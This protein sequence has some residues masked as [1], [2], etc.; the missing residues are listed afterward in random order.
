MRASIAEILSRRAVVSSLVAGEVAADRYQA[1][2][3]AS[4]PS[5]SRQSA[6]A[7]RMIGAEGAS[8]AARAAARS[9]S[10]KRPA[11]R[12]AAATRRCPSA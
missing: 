1:A 9:A 5:R 11:P 12:Q 8:R 6:T 10:S 7:D 3:S 2:A 4:R